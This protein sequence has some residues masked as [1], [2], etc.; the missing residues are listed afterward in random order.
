MLAFPRS[1]ENM[2]Q[3]DLKMT[4]HTSKIKAKKHQI[5]NENASLCDLKL[6]NFTIIA[7]FDIVRV[8]GEKP[9]AAWL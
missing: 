7:D 3:D 9:E 6:N 2:A 4:G 8:V 5:C 1:S